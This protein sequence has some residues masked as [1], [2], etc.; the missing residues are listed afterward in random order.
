MLS[1]PATHQLTGDGYAHRRSVTATR[2]DAR[3]ITNELEMEQ[4]RAEC[5]QAGWIR[6]GERAVPW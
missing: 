2:D 4:T 6:S 3:T 5:A 1:V